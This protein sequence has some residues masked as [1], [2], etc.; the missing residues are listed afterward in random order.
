V[1]GRETVRERERE[2]GEKD[3]KG[4]KKRRTEKSGLVREERRESERIG[5]GEGGRRKERE[6]ERTRRTSKRRGGK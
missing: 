6:R 1:R 4:G 5:R 2:S 3:C